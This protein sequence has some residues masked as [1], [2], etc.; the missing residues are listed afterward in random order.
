MTLAKE[1]GECLITVGEGDYFFR[2]SFANIMRIGDPQEI[3]QVFYDIHND[4]Q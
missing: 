4:E 1:I 3:V 2:T